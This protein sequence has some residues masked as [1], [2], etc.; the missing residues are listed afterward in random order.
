MNCNKSYKFDYKEFDFIVTGDEK[1]E[2][3]KKQLNTQKIKEIEN[4][5]PP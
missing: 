4:M 3:L 1:D 5:V 2:V